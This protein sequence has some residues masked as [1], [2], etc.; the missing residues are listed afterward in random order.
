M[1]VVK[2]NIVT[3]GMSGKLDDKIVFR[4][5]GERTI[6][7]TKP[8]PSNREP[9]EA[10]L[11]HQSRFRQ[12]AIYAKA[13]IK[14]EELGEAYKLAAK[15]SKTKSPFNIAVA[16]FLNVP[17][18]QDVDISGY[19]GQADEAIIVKAFD[20]FLV[21]QVRVTI[22]KPDGVE[23]ENGLAEQDEFGDWRF[24]TTASND[25]VDGSKIIIEVMDHPGNKAIREEVKNTPP[26]EE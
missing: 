7:S 22:Q 24:S 25:S 16:D 21:K 20:D 14:T 10:E 6:V 8:T 19:T 5:V 4:N 12:A 9:S 23:V 26:S 11:G 18:I 3:E 2:K 1:A 13:V 17:E 15:T